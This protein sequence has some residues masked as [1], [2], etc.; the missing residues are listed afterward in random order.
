MAIQLKSLT[1]GSPT[2]DNS[3]A[4]QN[5]SFNIIPTANVVYELYATPNAVPTV[6]AAVVRA[7]R[8][9]NTHT[10]PVKVTLYYNKPNASGQN[11]R[12]LLTPVDMVL[13]PNFVYIDDTEIT[14]DP[15]DGI[16]AKAE[17]AAVIQYLI[18]GMERDV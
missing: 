15:G 5:D 8:L 2:L 1:K 14:M 7:I 3:F 12:R 16:Q 18:S 17:T 10:A 9:V 6:R 13:P 4:A 11:R